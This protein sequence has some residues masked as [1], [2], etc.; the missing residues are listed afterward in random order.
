LYLKV[1]PVTKSLDVID[2][3]TYF[4]P[5]TPRVNFCVWPRMDINANGF[6]CDQEIDA[7]YSISTSLYSIQDW[8]RSEH[9][10]GENG[11]I[12]LEF[13]VLDLN[14]FVQYAF[15]KNV[16]ES[17]RDCDNAWNKI[18]EEILKPMIAKLGTISHKEMG[19]I[20][21][22]HGLSFEMHCKT[23]DDVIRQKQ[24][25]DNNNINCEASEIIGYHRCTPN[26]FLQ[27]LEANPQQTNFKL[28]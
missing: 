23:K 26:T 16:W 12:L 5:S 14:Q 19:V 20:I 27:I 17:P 25:Q 28:I 11:G 6:A 8:F 22:E 21:E 2:V 24:C 13:H 4:L 9:D 10:F 3:R 7:H 18:S 1:N 15:E